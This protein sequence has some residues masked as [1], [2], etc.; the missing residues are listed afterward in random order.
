[1]KDPLI[2]TSTELKG[3]VL[4]FQ[5][6]FP[7]YKHINTGKH[8][9]CKR[10]VH[11]SP[12]N[13]I[14]VKEITTVAPYSLLWIDSLDCFQKLGENRLILRLERLAAKKRKPLNI[15]RLQEL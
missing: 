4:L 2:L 12:R 7:I 13:H 10:R 3:N 6:K 14:L 11:L 1:M 8:P 9:V 5:N 15:R